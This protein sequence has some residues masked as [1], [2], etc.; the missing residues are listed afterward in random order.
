MN[1]QGFPFHYL[2]NYQGSSENTLIYNIKINWLYPRDEWGEI[3]NGDEKKWDCNIC[4]LIITQN[5]IWLNQTEKWNHSFN[6]KCYDCGWTWEY[7]YERQ[8]HT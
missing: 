5:E 7:I 8:I 1:K 2:A 6:W 3:I 4:K